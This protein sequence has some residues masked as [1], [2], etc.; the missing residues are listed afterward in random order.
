M[1]LLEILNL[2]PD[3][4]GLEIADLSLRLVKIKK[5]G[6]KNKIEFWAKKELPQGIIK[7]GEI[8]QVDILAE[9]IKK[10][11]FQEK[12]IRTNRVVV[13]LPEEKS[14]FQVIRLPKMGEEDLK[15]A[16]KNAAEQYIP[17]SREKMYLDVEIVP[18]FREVK[19]TKN[20]S[21]V[22]LIAI[23][24]TTVDLYLQ[25]LK[26]AELAPIVLETESQSVCRS[27]I[28]G[29]KTTAPVLIVSIYQTRTILTFFAGT[30]IRFTTSI[31]FSE[32]ILNQKIV[33]A[34][35]VDIKEAELLKNKNGLKKKNQEGEEVFRILLPVLSD[36]KYQIK[37][38]IDYYHTHIIHDFL[39]QK[40]TSV[41]KIILAGSGAKLAGL[42][43]FLQENLE[44]PTLLANPLINVDIEKSKTFFKDNDSLEFST[45][46]GLAMRAADS[47]THD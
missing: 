26:K 16:A 1:R 22:L 5:S 9:N 17:F 10:F 24:K 11:V 43:K 35:N 37:K 21:E 3:S 25:T 32:N 20:F 14:F 13:A 29:G 45:A 28:A 36:L 6:G 2:K 38:Y 31:P 12:R 8:Q 33:Q 34:M 30:S 18:L 41:K 46:I 23:P 42:E 40:E 4:F 44:T 39:P 19:K 47:N 27:V 7:K 15:S